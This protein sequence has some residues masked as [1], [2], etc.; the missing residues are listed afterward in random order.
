[1]PHL[2]LATNLIKGEERHRECKAPKTMDRQMPATRSLPT[3]L[4][5][6]VEMGESMGADRVT[7]G[8]RAV[9][10]AED[11]PFRRAIHLKEASRSIKT[12]LIIGGSHQPQISNILTTTR[13]AP[14][15]GAT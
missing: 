12:T 1:M 3:T 10:L 7:S 11:Q 4:D 14:T 8:L 2:D 15:Q 5:H 6:R 9:P 13:I